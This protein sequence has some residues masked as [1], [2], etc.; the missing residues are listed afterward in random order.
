MPDP[1][2]NQNRR[3]LVCGLILLLASLLIYGQTV[4]FE[5]I[6]LDD[7]LYIYQNPNLL[8]E[9]GSD[10]LA[11]A[12]TTVY[13]GNWHPLTWLSHM[14]D[15]QLFGLNAGYHHLVNVAIH[16]INAV[17]ILLFF[18]R[19][20]RDVLLAFTIA[21]LFAV[22]PLQVESVAWVAERKNLLSTTFWLLTMLCYLRYV[23]H[24]TL[25]SYVLVLVS[26]LLGLMCK[27]MLVTLPAALLLLDVWPLHRLRITPAGVSNLQAI[28]LQWQPL[29]TEK[30]PL[31]LLAALVAVV[32]I[33]AQADHQSLN[34]FQSVPMATRIANALV[35]YENYL[36]MTLW[37]SKLAFF[38]PHPGMPDP[39]QIVLSLLLL[40]GVT[41]G[42]LWQRHAY[43]G[44]LTGWLWYLGTL[45]PVIG[46]VQVG[47]QAMADR[48]I[49][50]PIIGLLLMIACLLRRWFRGHESVLLGVVMISALGLGGLAHH[51][52]GFWSNSNIMLERALAVTSRNYVV[53]EFYSRILV[54]SGEL[55]KGEIQ[56]RQALEIYPQ[57]SV[58]LGMLGNVQFSRGEPDAAIN[59]YQAALRYDAENWV[60]TYNLALSL[61]QKGQIDAGLEGLAETIR[62]KAD[63]PDVYRTLGNLFASMGDIDKAGFY[64]DILLKLAPGDAEALARMGSVKRAQ[65]SHDEAELYFHKALAIDPGQPIA[66]RE[67]QQS[68]NGG[69]ILPPTTGDRN[70]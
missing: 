57:S 30:L 65:G 61:L 15:Y 56:A 59:Y 41:G 60:V 28:R 5:F 25:S 33:A 45:V 23:E 17:L 69:L 10:S 46:L 22:H 36:M 38:Y 44:L 14:L 24:R 32:T 1:V 52:T 2:S 4:S 6:F 43:P 26:F 21:L 39:A 66:R 8:K 18:Q 9:F 20:T 27:S 29:V 53:H 58:A 12:I 64:Y 62:L 35:S 54:E 3:L 34:S 16:G 48:Y 55:D 11:W 67:L 63:F 68:E 37:P 47:R 7:A 40:G 49:Y 19:A 51:Q 50:V 70:E 42:V 13:G 31:F